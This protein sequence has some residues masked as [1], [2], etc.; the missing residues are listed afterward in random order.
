MNNNLIYNPKPRLLTVFTLIV[1]FFTAVLFKFLYVQVFSSAKLQAR[2]SEQ[3]YRDLPLV[4]RRG[5]IYDRNGVTLADTSTR[6]TI[7]VRPNAVEN[8]KEVAK[9]LSEYAGADYQKL[10]GKITKK[11]VGEITVAK[12]VE[13]DKVMS[14]VRKNQKGI[15]I[16][17]D[18]F[19]YYPYGDFMTQVLGFTNIDLQ[20][21]SGLESYYDK[22]L[23]GVNGSVLSEADLVGR[24]IG[25]TRYYI[26][27]TS[28]ADLTLTVDFYIQ[29]IVENTIKKAMLQTK[30]KRVSCLVMN[31]M[32]GEI[33]AMAETPSYDLNNVPRGDLSALF[34]YS[35]NTMVSAVYEPGSTFKILTSAIAI[36]ENAFPESHRFYC[37]GNRIVDGKRIKCWRSKG[38]GSQT[39]AEGVRNSCN[40][41]F[42][43]CALQVGTQKFY[44]YL[45]NFGI[46]TKTG[47]DVTGETRGITLAENTVK[48]VD[49]AR[50]G[51]GQAVA[52]TPIELA[53]ATSAVINGGEIVTPYLLKSAT[54]ASGRVVKENNPV[55]KNRVISSA[56]S[57]KL[58]K[59]LYSVVTEGSGKGAY[60]NGYDVGGKT[61]T[62]QKYENGA[63][64]G[65]K[66]ISSFLGFEKYEGHE[67][68]VLFL[69]DEPVGA[70][71][72]SIVAAPFVKEIFEGMFAYFG[73]APCITEESDKVASMPFNPY[74]YEY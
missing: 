20:G 21:Q 70:Y 7:Y 47:I 72:G 27:S 9:V 71:Y 62:A 31:P 15:Y 49:L 67:A 37:A 66:Y 46:M 8:P 50:I 11:G 42:M 2:A 25:G 73:I 65:G 28:G 45:K 12:K 32:T 18:G 30:A 3:W 64:A 58:I 57:E 38:H 61:G 1:F 33:L 34:Q 68:V 22:Y 56:T 5:G 19:R 55:V 60:I 4:A 29:C 54:D 35:K 26:P 39:F 51:F 36:E 59:I 6:Y 74:D 14:I 53:V 13:K 43:D 24:S 48:N 63:I 23:T 41:V 17:E 16:S 52:L 69:V 10:L 44:S 40:C